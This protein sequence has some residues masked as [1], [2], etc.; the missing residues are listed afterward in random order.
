MFSFDSLFV[1]HYL[2]FLASINDHFCFS[3]PNII[4]PFIGSDMENL[5]KFT[6]DFF[7][8]KVSK[9]SFHLNRFNFKLGFPFQMFQ[10]ES[11][12][13]VLLSIRE[14][15]NEKFKVEFKRVFIYHIFKVLSFHSRFNSLMNLHESHKEI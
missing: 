2:L 11:F 1:Q 7:F 3:L 14:E 8:F 12:F 4:N 13:R 9:F 15:I 6:F 10:F 5:I